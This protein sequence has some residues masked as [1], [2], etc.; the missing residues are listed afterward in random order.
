M[1]NVDAPLFPDYIDDAYHHLSTIRLP[2]F[3]GMQITNEPYGA[4]SAPGPSTGETHAAANKELDPEEFRAIV[5]W[6]IEHDSQIR[7]LL[8]PALVEQYWEMRDLVIEGL[9]DENP[10]DVVPAI[11]EP[12]ELAS[13][14][15]LVAL[16]VGGMTANGE[17]RFGLELGCN[18]EEEHGAGVRFIGLRVVEAGHASEAF[19]F[20]N[21]EAT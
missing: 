19:S 20:P 21:D 1:Y 4:V 16:H 13:L 18:W 10:D 11:K 8:F 9:I 3:A 15:G 7:A 14:C 12:E 5:Q 17:P 6:V 2:A